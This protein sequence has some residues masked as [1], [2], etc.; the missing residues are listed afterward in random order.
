MIWCNGQLIH[1]LNVDTTRIFGVPENSCSKTR[2]FTFCCRMNYSGKNGGEDKVERWAEHLF[3][4]E[5]R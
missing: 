5:K 4:L 3:K 1:E 2:E